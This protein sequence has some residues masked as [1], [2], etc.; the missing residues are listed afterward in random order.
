MSQDT[1]VSNLIINKLTK[2]Q[3]EGIENPD[4]TQLYLTTDELITSEDVT[5]ALGYTPLEE[6][7][8]ASDEQLGGIKVGEGLSITED[9]VL[10]AEAGTSLANITNAGKILISNMAMPSSSYEALIVGADGTSYQAPSNGWVWFKGRSNVSDG[11]IWLGSSD[12]Y[13]VSVRSKE[14]YTNSLMLPVRKS[15]YF[16]IAYD[17]NLTDIPE[18]RFYYAVGSESEAN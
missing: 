11:Q 3:F 10:S 12:G 8:I 1:N 14:M 2:A 17:G 4:P 7:P 18:L 6:V 13:S 15:S 5:D 16:S 9:G